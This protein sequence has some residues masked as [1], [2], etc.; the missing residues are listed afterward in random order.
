VKKTTF[1]KIGLI[2]SITIFALFWG[3]NFL[4][5]KGTFNNDKLF[6]VVYDRID[7]LNVSNPVLINGF[8]VGQ[9][10]NIKFLPDTSGRLVVELA[11]KNEVNIPG[12]T[13]ARIFSSDLMGTKAIEL[14]FGDANYLHVS[15]DTLIPDFEGSLQEMVSVQMLP[16]KNK[17]EDLM[18]QM[19]EAIEIITY[20]FNEETRKDIVSTFKNLKVTFANLE[21]STTNLDSLVRTGKIR[22]ENIIKNV[23]SITKNLEENNETITHAL[24]NI[25]NISDSLAQSNLKQTMSETYKLLAQLNEITTKVN[26]SE[27]S[28]GQLINNDTLYNNIEDVTYNLNRLVEDLRANPKRYVQFSAVKFGKTVYVD[29]GDAD[30]KG[31]KEKVL[32]KIKIGESNKSLPLNPENFKGYKNVEEAMVGGIYFYMVGQKKNIDSA[33]E[34][35]K[36]VQ[37]DYPESKIIEIKAGKYTVVE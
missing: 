24:Q 35:L 25:S 19:E 33:R 15:G 26:N 23:E 36:E 9:I 10:R 14:I 27:G 34:Y 21:S 11:I 32:Y 16:L 30:T 2:T 22:M 29:E 37:I 8:A 6:Y 20:I 13:V 17:A 7:G 18:K 3:V 5:S 1:I 12:K 4:K 31:K 28:L